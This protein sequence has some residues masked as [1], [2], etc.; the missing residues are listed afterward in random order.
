MWLNRDEHTRWWRGWPAHYVLFARNLVRIGIGGF[1]S[2]LSV[3]ITAKLVWQPG[4]PR[5][6]FPALCRHVGWKIK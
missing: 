4:S 5:R 3:W 1:F 2:A 6:L